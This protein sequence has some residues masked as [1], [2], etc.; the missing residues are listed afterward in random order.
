MTISRGPKSLI[1]RLRQIT[2][3]PEEY[4]QFYGLRQHGILEGRPVTEIIYVHSK[5]MIID[6]EVIVCG[7]ANINERSLAGNRDS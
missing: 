5:L 7:S 2:N 4:L 6:D 3:Q 1:G